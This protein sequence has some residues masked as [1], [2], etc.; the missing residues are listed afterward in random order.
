MPS[1]RVRSTLNKSLRAAVVILIAGVFVRCTGSHEQTPPRLTPNILLVTVD[2]LRA[3]AIGAYGNASAVTPRMDQLA[4]RGIRFVRAHAHNVVTL[5]SHANLLSGLLPIDHGVRD[6]A[7]FRFPA[8]LDTIATLLKAR[9]YRTGAFISAFPL[10]RRF[11]LARG[12]DEYDD[13]FVDATPRPAFLEQERRGTDTVARARAWVDRDTHTPT[14]C[15]VHRY[16]PPV[17]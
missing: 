2:T 12:F 4:R 8:T 7:G 16:E 13:R 6:N 17:P 14:F 5:P 9:R 1:P 3:D 10:D 15:W 11:G